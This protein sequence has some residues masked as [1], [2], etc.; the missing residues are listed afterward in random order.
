MSVRLILVDSHCHL[1]LDQFDGDRDAALKRARLAGVR[2]IVNPGIDLQT[3]RHALQLAQATTEIYV[4]VGIHPNS[5]G[6]FSEATL[7]ELR[8]LAMQPKVVAIGEIGLDYYW[9]KVDHAQQQQAFRAQL[10]LAAEVGLPV[11]IHSRDSNQ[12]VARLLAEWV[13]SPTFRHSPLANRPFAGV[14]HAFSGD[15]A[16]AEAAYKWNFLL[17]LGGPATFKNARSLHTLVPQLRLDRLL[18]ETDAPYLTPHPH[19]GKRNEPAYVALVCEQIA[20]LYGL[21]PTEIAMTTSM[22]AYQFFGLENQFVAESQNTHPA[23]S[24]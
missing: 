22:L 19:R 21:A 17:S 14:L 18:L 6:D 5:S 8:K 11:I 12:D 16:L 4:A 23:I 20:A 3:C 10:N 2:L 7:D 13:N 15:L 9:Q 1:D 24:T